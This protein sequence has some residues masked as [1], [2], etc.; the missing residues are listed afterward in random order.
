MTPK[1]NRPEEYGKYILAK[2]REILAGR[3][4]LAALKTDAWNEIR[5]DVQGTVA[6]AGQIEGVDH[7]TLVEVM[8]NRAARAREVCQGVKVLNED[9]ARVMFPAS[10][11]D[12]ILCPMTLNFMPQEKARGVLARFSAWLRMDGVLYLVSWVG[13]TGYDD[14]AA[15]RTNEQRH[16]QVDEWER[17]ITAL[18]QITERDL[19]YETLALGGPIYLVGYRC[20]KL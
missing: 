18:F 1:V 11:F 7:W 9:L 12:A 10:S 14:D 4:G 15:Q 8:A 3:T 19:I 2:C 13:E 20:V 6:I 17:A 5:P 16:F